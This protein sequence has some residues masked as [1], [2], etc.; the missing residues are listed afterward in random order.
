LL[1]KHTFN[2]EELAISIIPSIHQ[3]F[4]DAGPNS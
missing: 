3:V 1:S 2:R 4:A